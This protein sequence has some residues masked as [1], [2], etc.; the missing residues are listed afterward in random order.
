M[1]DFHCQRIDIRL[2]CAVG[3]GKGL[4]PAALEPVQELNN[5]LPMTVEPR[6]SA[7]DAFDVFAINDRRDWA[8]FFIIVVV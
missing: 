3:I 4:L 1:V 2:Q 6:P 5:P 7:S 8:S